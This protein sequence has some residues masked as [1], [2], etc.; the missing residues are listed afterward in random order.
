MKQ[1]TKGALIQFVI[2]I[3]FA[4]PVLSQTPWETLMQDKSVYIQKKIM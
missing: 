2:F 1:L 4:N 3:F